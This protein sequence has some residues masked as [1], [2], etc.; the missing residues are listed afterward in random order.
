MSKEQ[1]IEGAL[2][3]NEEERESLAEELWLS[4]HHSS[5]EEI[6]K[7]WIEEVEKRMESVRNG[8]AILHNGPEV[9]GELRAKYS[10]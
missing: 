6:E 9:M 1:I 3:L 10:K 4:V 2:A 8:T 7:I 5:P